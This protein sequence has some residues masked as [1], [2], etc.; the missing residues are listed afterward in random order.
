[1]TFDLRRFKSTF[2]FI[3]SF[4]FVD[5]VCCGLVCIQEIKMLLPLSYIYVYNYIHI[6]TYGIS[7]NR[8]LPTPFL[9]NLAEE[10]V[11]ALL[12]IFFIL[13]KE[14]RML[15]TPLRDKNLI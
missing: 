2:L 6:R 7:E 3:L 8:Y 13:L 9:K 12:R 10:L 15:M 5:H 14:I 11:L 1:M 4:I